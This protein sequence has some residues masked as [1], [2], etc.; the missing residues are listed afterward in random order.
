MVKID[1]NECMINVFEACESMKDNPDDINLLLYHQALYEYM[2]QS[3]YYINHGKSLNKY[4][5][6]FPDAIKQ[7]PLF[8]VIKWLKESIA[9][10]KSIERLIYTEMVHCL[11]NFRY[12]INKPSHKIYQEVKKQNTKEKVEQQNTK[13][14]VKS[15]NE[16]DHDIKYIHNKKYKSRHAH[17]STGIIK[18]DCINYAD[19]VMNLIDSDDY[20]RQAQKEIYI[21]LQ[22]SVHENM[23][24]T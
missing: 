11:E 13:E 20:R 17:G 16:I 8:N 24:G 2:N 23:Q 12:A 18:Y 15:N 10:T 19:M 21:L 14:N 22:Q 9:N 5:K 6:I 4:R 1:I 3:L 7:I